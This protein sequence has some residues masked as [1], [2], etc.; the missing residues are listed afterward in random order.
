MS[1][2]PEPVVHTTKISA[3]IDDHVFILIEREGRPT[4][5]LDLT[6]EG[7]SVRSNGYFIG[8]LFVD[9]ERTE[10][11]GDST[12]LHRFCP[13]CGER[14]VLASLRAHQCERDV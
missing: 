4:T 13:L 12:I 8:S 10:M 9:V 3:G 6:G 1:A 7:L 11:K 5:S 14:L 2:M